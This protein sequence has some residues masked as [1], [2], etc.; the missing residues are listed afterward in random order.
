MVVVVDLPCSLRAAITS[1]YREFGSTFSSM[2]S[3]LGSII[4]A[5]CTCRFNLGAHD[6]LELGCRMLCIVVVDDVVELV[7]LTQLPPGEREALT[8]LP[9]A[10]GRPARRRRSSS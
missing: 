2:E 10:F 9:A 7:R 8:D 4:A 5:K 3:I 6:A 1:V